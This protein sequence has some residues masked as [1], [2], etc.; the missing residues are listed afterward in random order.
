MEIELAQLS[1]IAR[2]VGG[3]KREIAAVIRAKDQRVKSRA[4]LHN[5]LPEQ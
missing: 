3:E 1:V 2:A 5:G 4:S